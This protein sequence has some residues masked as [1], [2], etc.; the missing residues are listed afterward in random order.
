MEFHLCCPN[1]TL[2][3]ISNSGVFH[4]SRFSLSLPFHLRP[5]NALIS[6]AIS[7]SLDFVSPDHFISGCRQWCFSSLLIHCPCWSP[8]A[9][10]SAPNSWIVEVNRFC[11]FV[12]YFILALQT[13]WFQPNY[14]ALIS[15]LISVCHLSFPRRSPPMV[16]SVLTIVGYLRL[17]GS[18]NLALDL[19]NPTFCLIIVGR[20]RWIL[21]FC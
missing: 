6:M 19:F 13:I 2:H 11:N 14:I 21:V 5:K 12:L 16:P 7:L 20:R 18:L 9:L 15:L 17:V 3:F 8:R 10:P 4:L 1:F